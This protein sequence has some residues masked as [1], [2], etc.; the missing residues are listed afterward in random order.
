[1]AAEDYIDLYP[2][3]DYYIQ[4][5]ADSL[6]DEDRVIHCDR[7]SADTYYQK[8]YTDN[9][10]FNGRRLRT[11]KQI[12]TRQKLM[13]ERQ[14]LIRTGQRTGVSMDLNDLIGQ[15]VIVEINKEALI[16]MPI[17]KEQ[18]AENKFYVGSPTVFIN[19]WGHPTLDEAIKHAQDM[20]QKN[21]NLTEVSIVEIVRVVK[22]KPIEVDIETV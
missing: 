12:E 10:S 18:L 8:A 6:P 20:F 16:A 21:K 17:T 14:G 19:K 13:A 5:G 22:R 3:E 1:M 15:E 7:H 4:H 9:F 11:R 2:D